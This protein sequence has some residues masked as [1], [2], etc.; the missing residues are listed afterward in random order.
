MP[1][2]ALHFTNAEGRRYFEGQAPKKQGRYRRASP[3]RR[4]VDGRVFAS[5]AEASHY[6]ELKARVLLGEIDDLRCQAV[7]DC[8]VNGI[9]VLR[10]TADFQFRDVGTGVVHYVEVKS[11]TSGKERDW[12]LRRNLVEALFGVTIDVVTR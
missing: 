3:D 1:R 7:F 6:Q 9:K 10:Y 2:P 11:G 5:L 4:T 12:K 8:V